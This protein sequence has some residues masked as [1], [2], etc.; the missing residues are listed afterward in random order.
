MY[1]FCV[2]T[3]IQQM[4]TSHTH[5]VSRRWEHVYILCWD[6]DTTNENTTCV[7][8][9]RRWH[10]KWEHQ[11]II[12]FLREQRTSILSHNYTVSQTRTQQRRTPHDHTLT[13]SYFAS[14]DSITNENTA[15]SYCFSD[16][17]AT[18]GSTYMHAIC[19]QTIQQ[20]R[21]PHSSVSQTMTQQMK[22]QVS[23]LVS[24]CFKPSQPQRIISGLRET[25]IKRCLVERTNKAELRPEEQSE[26]AESCRENLW[27]EIQLKGP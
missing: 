20:M 2:E 11:T 22:T 4:E 8:C 6:D 17:D 15:Q 5:S 10:D 16:D 23:L 18:N 25:F 27:N 13:Q 1:A 26:T 19:I 12:L 3:R 21:K 24:W 7:L 9:P 14:D